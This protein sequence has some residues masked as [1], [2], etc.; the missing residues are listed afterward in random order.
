MLYYGSRPEDLLETYRADLHR[1]LA[2]GADYV[3]FHVSDISVEEGYTYRWQHTDEEVIDASAEVINLILEGFPESFD[4]LVENQWWP[5]FTFTEPAK[6]DRL[7]NA[8]GRS[9]KGIMLDTGHLMNANTVLRSQAEGVDWILRCIEAHG[10]TA[11][12]IRGMHFHQSVSGEYVRTHTGAVPEDLPKDYLAGFSQNYRHIQQID[13]HQPWTEPACARIIE[14]VQPAYLTHE[15][16]A[17]G[18]AWLN[19]AEVQLHALRQFSS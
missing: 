14:R 16:A 7:L 12:M 15:L 11:K 5:G 4:F 6:T 10:E 9:R 19:A 13:R 2:L 17:S 18:R 1:A 3:V 8:I